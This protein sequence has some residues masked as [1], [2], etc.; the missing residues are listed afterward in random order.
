MGCCRQASNQATNQ[1]T[2]KA[3]DRNRPRSGQWLGKSGAGPKQQLLD[4]A[5]ELFMRGNKSTHK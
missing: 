3:I 5:S 2:N 1:A 4:G